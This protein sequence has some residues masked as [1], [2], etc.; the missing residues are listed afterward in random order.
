MAKKNRSKTSDPHRAARRRLLDARAGKVK[1]DEDR[2]NELRALAHRPEGSLGFKA[3][4]TY[5]RRPI[6]SFDID[7]EYVDLL[8]EC[9]GLDEEVLCEAFCRD[10]VVPDEPDYSGRAVRPD[11]SREHCFDV[12]WRH[13]F[14]RN[15]PRDFDAD[16]AAA[17]QEEVFHWSVFEEASR[18]PGRSDTAQ[19]LFVTALFA[20]GDGDFENAERLLRAAASIGASD[21]V[22]HWELV[23][24]LLSQQGEI[25]EVISL[26]EQMR[27][28]W[29]DHFLVRMHCA[30]VMVR[31]GDP[32]VARPIVHA[33]AKEPCL[34]LDEF[35]SLMYVLCQYFSIAGD[36]DALKEVYELAEAHLDEPKLLQFIQH[37]L[38]QTRRRK[39][40]P[41][42]KSFFTRLIEMIC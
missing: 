10:L 37:H 14:W 35:R 21:P 5:N 3:L 40:P 12:E 4:G 7:G 27:E 31:L 41:R 8:A 19:L 26:S 22:I 34:T 28:R 33:L 13:D 6:K 11:V 24:A 39:T 18:Y 15:E 20:K 2:K 1:L 23:R 38:N 16:E 9:G 17:E 36:Y 25:K 30:D 32:D 29:P 42:T